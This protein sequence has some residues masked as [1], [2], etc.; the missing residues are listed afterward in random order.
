MEMNLVLLTYLST[1][2][3][4]CDGPESSWR[5][6]VGGKQNGAGCWPGV[7]HVGALMHLPSL[8]FPI[9]SP[10]RTHLTDISIVCARVFM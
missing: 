10:G 3:G 4:L 2:G 6:S 9:F 1:R 8:D 5:K 7:V